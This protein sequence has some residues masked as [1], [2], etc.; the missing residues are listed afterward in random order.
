MQPTVSLSTTEA[1][2]RVITDAL[3][4]IIYFRR[5]LTEIGIENSEPTSIM[6]DN[7]SCIKLVENPV[8]HSRTKHIGLQY[9]F[10]REAS[11][12]GEVHVNYILTTY[13][14]ADFLTKPLSKTL[15][16]TNR[17]SAGIIQFLPLN[18]SINQH[19]T[20][21]EPTGVYTIH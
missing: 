3:K 5:L 13:Q 7:Q 6:S 10:I 20:Y 19:K 11:K 4:D 17:Q 16:L 9:H 14:Q 1:E 15:F 18:N 8:L 2:Y 12:S 21:P